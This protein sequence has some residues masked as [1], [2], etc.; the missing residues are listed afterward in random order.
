M[1]YLDRKIID[2][3]IEKTFQNLIYGTTLLIEQNNELKNIKEDIEQSSNA[4]TSNNF[5]SSLANN[6]KEIYILKDKL[7]KELIYFLA[8]IKQKKN[9]FDLLISENS[10]LLSKDSINELKNLPYPSLQAVIHFT[11]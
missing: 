7:F 9:F 8:E 3:I 6:N 4:P 1:K 11:D 10:F 5:I 2:E